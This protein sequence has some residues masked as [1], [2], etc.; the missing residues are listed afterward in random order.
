VRV[1]KNECK[2]KRIYGWCASK[3][4]NIDAV[5]RVARE[6][7]H[8]DIQHHTRPQHSVN[9]A[10]HGPGPLRRQ[11]PPSRDRQRWLLR[12]LTG[13][14]LCVPLRSHPI[15]APRA[16]MVFFEKE[17]HR[18]EG[19]VMSSRTRFWELSGGREDEG[20]RNLPFGGGAKRASRMGQ[21]MRLPLKENAWS[22]HQHLFEKNVGKTK[23]EKV[24]SLH[25]LKMRVLELFTHGED[26]ST[27]RARHKGRQPLIK[28][29]NHGFKAMYFPF[30]CYL[31]PFYFSLFI[32]FYF[33]GVDKGVSLAPTYSS[34][35]M[36]KSDLRNSLRTKCWLICFFIFFERLILIVNKSRL[37]RWTFETI[38]WFL[39]R[40]ERV[41]KALDLETI[42]SSL[43][44]GESLRRW[45]LKRPLDF[46]EERIVKAL[47]LWTISW[48]FLWNEEVY[49]LVLFGFDS[50]IFNPFLR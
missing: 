17:D 19:R 48:F 10:R 5:W 18:R 43:K 1:K 35:A 9:G 49:E 28:C 25:I 44:G 24:E 29:T 42:F 3:E 47:D 21:M 31:F 20:C 36:R 34:I 23:M 16:Q 40:G 7:G 50:L 14:V 41:I 15:D 6:L 11:A 39:K 46:W 26:I 33:F 32:F 22:R 30:L 38:F 2:E 4:K 27:P 45:T 8:D 37:R 13:A 12:W